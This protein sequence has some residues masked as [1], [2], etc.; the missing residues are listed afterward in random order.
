M[1]K[2]T[3]KQL[4]DMAEEFLFLYNSG[5]QRTDMMIMML[6]QMT[7]KPPQFIINS[8]HELCKEQVMKVVCAWCKKHLNGDED[9]KVVSHG[10]CDECYDRA[11]KEY[12]ESYNKIMKE[13]KDNE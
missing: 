4:K 12:E 7:Q 1:A 8:I 10:I 5:D 13:F 6:S 9:D 11:T 2:Y 3:D